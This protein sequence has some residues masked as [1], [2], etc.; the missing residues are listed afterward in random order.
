MKVSLLLAALFLVTR[1]LAEAPPESWDD[2]AKWANQQHDVGDGQGHGPDVGGDEWASAL[3]RQL[4]VADKDSHGPDLKSAEW[5]A[6]VEK[7][8]GELNKREL[9]SSHDTISK[10]TGISDHRCRGLTSLCPDKCG[11]SGRMAHFAIVKYLA[12]EKPGEFG[13]EKQETFNVLIEDNMKHAKVPAEILKAIGALEPGAI[14]RLKWNHDYVTKAGS[15][16]P[17]RPIT[18][19]EPMTPEQVEAA[20]KAAK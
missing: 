15:K 10:F 1:V 9:L 18:G 7:K 13:D 16:F 11:H 20:T 6:A 19:I 14:V 8:L 17:E 3:A 2:W 12:Y 4:G 5:R